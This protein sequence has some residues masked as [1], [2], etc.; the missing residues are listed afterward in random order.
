MISKSVLASAVVLAGA[1][2]SVGSVHAAD[3]T[4][5]LGHHVSVDHSTSSEFIQYFADLVGANSKG[6]I[7]IQVYPAGQLGGQ[8]ELLEALEIGAI[9]MS[10][11]DIGIVSNYD[12]ALGVLDLPYVFTDMDHAYR[13]MQEGLTAKVQ[14]HV[15]AAAEF[16]VLS[17][18]PV[19]FRNVLLA[20]KTIESIEDLK[21]VK[22]RTPSS[23]VL[24]ETFRALGA[25]PTP[26]PSG[27]AYTSIQTHVVDGMEGHKEFLHSIQVYEVAKSWAETRHNLTFD[28]LNISTATWNKLNEGQQAI[29]AEA[30]VE[31]AE[32]FGVAN[33]EIDEDF[34]VKLEE[35]GVVFHYMDLEP[36][37]AKVR[38]MIDAFISENSADD[39]WDVIEATR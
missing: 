15:E 10:Y 2:L 1:M 23:P 29:V 8:R 22:I 31:A 32:H 34:K 20:N 12:L 9:D 18:I 38:P 33:H 21:G 13:A 14:E 26:I 17:M 11:S 25:N 24:I 5:R 3:V 4:M 6:A 37:Q 39:L 7:D 36:F 28:T 16:K 30:A 35:K 19:A 27:D